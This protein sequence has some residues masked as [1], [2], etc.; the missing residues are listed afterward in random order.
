[1]GTTE[2]KSY[3]HYKTYNVEILANIQIFLFYSLILQKH[4]GFGRHDF[5]YAPLFFKI[6]SSHLV[7]QQWKDQYIFILGCNSCH[8]WKQ[9]FIKTH[10]NR[11]KA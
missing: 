4:F 11:G 1:M 10:T 8:N 9:S 5:G 7:M 2:L 6:L 3:V